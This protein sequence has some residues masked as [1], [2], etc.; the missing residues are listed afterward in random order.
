MW[1]SPG[2]EAAGDVP[3]PSQWVWPDRRSDARTGI[4][5]EEGHGAP[6]NESEQEWAENT[7]VWYGGKGEMGS[8]QLLQGTSEKKVRRVTGMKLM[9][10]DHPCLRGM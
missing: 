10:V 3:P 7:M 8:N 9:P 1:G 5:E 4:S 6:W 2:W